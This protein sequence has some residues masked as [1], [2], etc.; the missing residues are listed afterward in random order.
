MTNPTVKLPLAS[1]TTHR[2]LQN[3]STRAEGIRE[4]KEVKRLKEHI[5]ELKR[6]IKANGQK[7]P[8]KVVSDGNTHWLVDGYHRHAAMTELESDTINAEVIEGT[9]EAAFEQSMMANRQ[10]VQSLTS[11]Q[12]VQNAWRAITNPYTDTYREILINKGQRAL[13]TQLG[14]SESTIRGM[15]KQLKEWARDEINAIRSNEFIDE[16]TPELSDSDLDKYWMGHCGELYNHIAYQQWRE[17]NNRV[18]TQ[19]DIVRLEFQVQKAVE[20]MKNMIGPIQEEQG[21]LVVRAALVEILKDIDANSVP[22]PP[23]QSTQPSPL[24]KSTIDL[25][26]IALPMLDDF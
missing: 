17:F 4:D 23:A 8:V 3:R 6:D 24:I 12:R 25:S 7:T 5:R 9:F 21:S 22:S 14:A 19:T 18:R 1:I 10:I 26:V 13:A 11:K 2:E 16:E 15:R 20:Q